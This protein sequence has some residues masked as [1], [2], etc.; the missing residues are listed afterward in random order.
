MSHKLS[1]FKAVS[2]SLC[3]FYKGSRSVRSYRTFKQEDQPRLRINS[4]APNFSAQTTQG[5]LNFYDYL[6]SSWGILFSHPADFTPVCTTELGAFSKL[7]PEFDKRNVKL[8][9]L[10]TESVENH[11]GWIKDIIDVS[12][13]DCFSFPIIADVD[14]EVAFLYDMVD[15]EGFENLDGGIVHTIRSV[16]VIDPSKKIRL[17]LTYPASVGRNIQEILRTVDALQLVDSKGIVCPVEWKKG[18]DVIIP[19]NVSD[20]EAKAKFGSFR[21]LK[22]YLRYTKV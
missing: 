9:G 16:F 17:T 21:A 19:P 10:S 13:L 11:Y 22:P 3:R 14:R 12:K 1:Y 15:K 6:D 18:E 8:I 2:Q 7:K 20:S 5:K 4:P